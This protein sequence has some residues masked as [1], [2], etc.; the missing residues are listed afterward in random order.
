MELIME[1]VPN[2]PITLIQVASMF[3]L[4]QRGGP[5]AR[6]TAR[7]LSVIMFDLEA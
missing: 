7:P 5:T 6:R 2:Y 3:K 1:I 4:E